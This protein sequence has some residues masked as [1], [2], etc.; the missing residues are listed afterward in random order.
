MSFRSSRRRNLSS[1]ARQFTRPLGKCSYGKPR[2]F[3]Q[4]RVIR[5]HISTCPSSS[6]LKPPISEISETGRDRPTRRGRELAP[7]RPQNR[8]IRGS[9]DICSPG[10]RECDSTS[11]SSLDSGSPQAEFG[12]PAVALHAREDDVLLEDSVRVPN[13]L[14]EIP[15]RAERGRR[16]KGSKD[17]GPG[18]IRDLRVFSAPRLLEEPTD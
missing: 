16:G 2:R 12:P 9:G 10:S 3:A 15:D 13:L 8:P 11:L 5:G 6:V 4:R 17:L 18:F 14:S 7:G 1:S